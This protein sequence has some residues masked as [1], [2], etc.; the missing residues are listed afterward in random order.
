[1]DFILA[2]WEW[3]LPVAFIVAEKI[4][5]VTPTP[6]DDIIL[7][8]IVKEGWKVVKKVLNV[9]GRYTGKYTR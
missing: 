1:M 9:Q 8:I 7:D 5:K 6:Y 4:V 3:L 2:N